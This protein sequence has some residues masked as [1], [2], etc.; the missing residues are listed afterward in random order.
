M[1][2][3]IDSRGQHWQYVRTEELL[4]LHRVAM[5]A[6]EAVEIAHSMGM[7]LGPLREA[8]AHTAYRA[9]GTP[10][11]GAFD[12]PAGVAVQED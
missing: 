8:L 9:A 11:V 10:P 5:E 4:A 2:D 1:P 12:P 7:H 6:R 3:E